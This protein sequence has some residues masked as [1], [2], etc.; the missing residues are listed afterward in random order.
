MRGSQ[1]RLWGL[2]EHLQ[3]RF[4]RSCWGTISLLPVADG[5]QRH[6]DPLSKLDLAAPKASTHALGKLGRIHH[7]IGLILRQMLVNASLGRCIHSLD[8]D[9]PDRFRAWALNVNLHFLIEP[10]RLHR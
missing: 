9:P 3:E 2:V 8:I 10:A 1:R 5:V 7:G 6:I 4:S